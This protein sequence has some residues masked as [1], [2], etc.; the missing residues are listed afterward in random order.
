MSRKLC[1]AL[2]AAMALAAS[3]AA[4]ARGK[5]HGKTHHSKHARHTAAVMHND[6]SVIDR[7]ADMHYAQKVS[8]LYQSRGG[9]SGP[10]AAAVGGTSDGAGGSM[11]GS[12]SR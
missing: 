12:G 5:T 9:M 3:P 8:C 10:Y 6:G 4:M 11:S 2:A 1:V 7:C